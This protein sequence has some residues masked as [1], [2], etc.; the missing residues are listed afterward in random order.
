VKSTHGLPFIFVLIIGLSVV[1]RM[2]A[3][4]SPAQAGDTPPQARSN[5]RAETPIQQLD[6]DGVSLEAVQARLDKKSA[7]LHIMLQFHG[8]PAGLIYARHRS[9]A[10]I[11][12]AANLAAAQIERIES[13]QD[14]ALSAIQRNAPGAQVLYTTQRV[15]NGIAMLVDPADLP[16]LSRLPGLKAIQPLPLHE[17]GHTSS[18]PLIGA[19]EVWMSPFSSIGQGIKIGIIDTGIDYLHKTFYGDPSLSATNNPTIIG[20]TPGYFPG[21]IKVVGGYDFAGDDYTGYNRPAP[22]PDPMDCNG[23]GT[24][25]AATA[26][27]YGVTMLGETYTGIYSNPLDYDDFRIG[28]GV[29]P[30]AELYALK[31]FGCS[32][33]TALTTLAIEWAIDP[34]GDG[35][36]LDRLDVLNLSLGSDFGSNGDPSA[37]ASNVAARIGIIV[38]ASAGNSGDTYYATS[39]P[40]AAT[41]AI[42][43][44][45]SVDGLDYLDGFEVVSTPGGHEWMVGV[46]PA[47]HSVY[48]NWAEDTTGDLFYPPT[49]NLGG[50]TEF[51]PG[52]FSGK[53]ALLDWTLI[54]GGGNECG[55]T[56]RVNNAEAAGAIGVLMVYPSPYLPISI[57]GNSTIPAT[58]T[59]ST[60]GDPIKAA[61]NAGIVRIRLTAEFD[62]TLKHL[63]SG[64]V[65]TLSD[66]TSRGVRRVDSFLK[67]DI[68]APG[69]S[70]FSAQAGSGSQG[71]NLSGTSMAAPHVAGGMALLRE[72]K[73]PTWSVAELKAL[74]MNTATH[75][76]FSGLNRTGD[77]YGPGRVGAGR[78]DIGLAATSQVILYNAE[79]E[80]AVSVSFGVVEVVG[81]HTATKEVRV[82]NKSDWSYDF[83]VSFDSR[84]TIPGVSFQLLDGNGNQLTSLSLAG[85]ESATIKVILSADASQM[86]HTRDNTVAGEQVFPRQWLSEAAGFIVLQ[87]TGAPHP[88]LRLAVHAAARPTSAMSAIENTVTLD[89]PTGSFVLNL[90]GA[91]VYVGVG[92]P[93]PNQASIVTAFELLGTSPDEPDG[94]DPPSVN[95][96]DIKYI[97]VMSNANQASTLNNPILSFGIATH[98]PWS[99]PN[100]VEFDIFI[101]KNRDGD[102]DFILFNWNYGSATGGEASDV[103]VTML[104]DLSLS[105]P[106]PQPYLNGAD[107]IQMNTVP[108]NNNVMAMLVYLADLDLDPANPEFDF[109]VQSYHRDAVSYPVDISE[110]YTYNPAAPR[111]DTSSDDFTG[112]PVWWD[113]NGETITVDYDLTVSDTPLQGVLLLHHFNTGGNSAE[114][115]AVDR[116]YYETFMPVI[117]R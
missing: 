70:I 33:S 32:G 89:N 85:G 100:E 77:R 13:V 18:V 59:V 29:A 7:G 8:E 43:T 11:Q 50:C 73:P 93:P 94:A 87:P 27:G 61:M 51:S 92:M 60:V 112:L 86:T 25:V 78:I 117:L 67:P 97:G 95:A 106:I 30:E 82:D 75:D 36:F 52:Y 84:V 66:Y 47:S 80:G 37:E 88:Q 9:S 64:Q 23:H 48:Y 45:S 10:G 14:V 24:H 4:V 81:T 16:T 113:F 19:A 42:S 46:H 63:F 56:T 116:I 83:A 38:V 40:G 96:A 79:D 101:D 68:T 35:D 103:F 5:E 98:A 28:P 21:G 44:A 111:L 65:D 31:V 26:A 17:P 62:G 102:A 2:A 109:W 41:W 110:V 3:P 22:D 12:S 105:V 58:I 91:D 55:S 104:Y 76:L 39:A 99:T 15:Y 57:A 54:A 71:V 53:V 108:F 34:N 74:V 1:V 6:S 115:I 20:D 90:S 107:L 72:I 114:V 49:G 69:Q